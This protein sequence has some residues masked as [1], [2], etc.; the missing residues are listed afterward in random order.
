MVTS[1]IEESSSL[2]LLEYIHGEKYLKGLGTGFYEWFPSKKYRISDLN[3]IF[4]K[5]VIYQFYKRLYDNQGY[6]LLT[7]G[8]LCYCYDRANKEKEELE[9][10]GIDIDMYLEDIDLIY[11]RQLITSWCPGPK[12]FYIYQNG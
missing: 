1:C 4:T 2:W 3:K 9:V 10:F 12:Q 11:T 6:D 7:K 5:S 8:E